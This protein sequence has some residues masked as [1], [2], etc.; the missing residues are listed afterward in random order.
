MEWFLSFLMKYLLIKKR[1]VAFKCKD[2]GDNI[3]NGCFN[4]DI[5]FHTTA[6]CLTICAAI[7]S[8]ESKEISGLIILINSAEVS[9]ICNGK[10]P[11]RWDLEVVLR[12]IHKVQDLS[13]LTW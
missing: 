7:I 2:R 9:R 13:G 12:D 3:L 4:Q 11:Y 1:G 10:Q 5:Q 6:I 8:L